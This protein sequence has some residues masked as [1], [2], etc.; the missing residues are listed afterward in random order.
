MTDPTAKAV[1]RRKFLRGGAIAAGTT[2]VGTLA[3]PAVLAQAPQTLRMLPQ[4]HN[5]SILS[6]DLRITPVPA[7]RRLV[8]DVFENEVIAL[9]FSESTKQFWIDSRLRVETRGRAAL[10]DSGLAPLPWNAQPYG[11]E[12]IVS[13]F[14]HE[15]AAQVGY[16]VNPFLR[17]LNGMMK[18]R[19][20]IENRVD[21][22]ANYGAETLRS[23][24]GACRDLSVLFIESVQSL[25]LL[26]RFVSGYHAFSNSH[27]E[28]GDLHAWVEVFLPGRGWIGFDPTH[29]VEVG[30]AYVPLCAGPTQADTMPIEG[31]Y[32]F[33]GQSLSSTLRYGVNI[34][35]TG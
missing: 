4:T 20:Q 7:T 15:L 8:R 18:D 21:G 33:E 1:S 13:Q 25:G 22:A 5:L 17:R 28:R 31:G 27:I 19:F 9:T 35:T 24:R 29:G 30:D 3:A 11:T 2:A 34:T 26:A 6:H 16:Q 10:V 23:G 12:S 32:T 14:A